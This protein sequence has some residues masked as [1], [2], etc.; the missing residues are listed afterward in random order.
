MNPVRGVI[1]IGIFGIQI[2]T[3]LYSDFMQ[4]FVYFKI[5]IKTKRKRQA[6]GYNL[7]WGGTLHSHIDYG[8]M[9]DFT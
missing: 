5:S 7:G 3:N 9:M 8:N 1:C 4:A 6:V 2:G